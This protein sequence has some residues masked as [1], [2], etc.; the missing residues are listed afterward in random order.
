MNKLEMQGDWNIVKG[1][2]KQR[3]A[4]L[5]DNDLRYNEGQEDELVGRIQKRLG[6]TREEVERLLRECG[7]E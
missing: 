1:R 6:E 2:L 3:F 4:K 5:T 7:K